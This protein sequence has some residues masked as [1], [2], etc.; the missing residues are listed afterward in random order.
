MEGKWGEVDLE[1]GGGIL[2]RLKLGTNTKVVG[3]IQSVLEKQTPPP[4][5]KH[6]RQSRIGWEG[7]VEGRYDRGQRIIFLKASLNV[8][9]T[10]FPQI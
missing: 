6:P 5:K 7:G 8:T 4:K 9:F 10:A 3:E 2:I 1:R